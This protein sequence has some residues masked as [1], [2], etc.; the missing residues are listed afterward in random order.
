MGPVP[1]GS[2]RATNRGLYNVHRGNW[3]AS[4]RCIHK[5]SLCPLCSRSL[6]PLSSQEG[7]AECIT[8]EDGKQRIA[9]ALAFHGEEVR[10]LIQ[11]DDHARS[12]YMEN[13]QRC[14]VPMSNSKSLCVYH[15]GNGTFPSVFPRFHLAP[16]YTTPQTLT[17]LVVLD[18]CSRH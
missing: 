6:T 16:C 2:T 7:V 11:P 1:N 8:N 18:T 3:Y 12:R 13:R 4:H 5:G 9:C 14:S 10:S 15:D 17:V